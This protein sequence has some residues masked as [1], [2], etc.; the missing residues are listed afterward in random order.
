MAGTRAEEPE[1][2]GQESIADVGLR[3]AE[4]QIRN[5]SPALSPPRENTDRGGLLAYGGT[6]SLRR[7]A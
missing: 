4:W 2:S 3:I 7:E 5:H 1:G 6:E